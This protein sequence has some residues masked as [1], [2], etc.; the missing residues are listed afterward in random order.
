MTSVNTSSRFV[1]Q[2]LTNVLKSLPV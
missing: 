2:H 1:D